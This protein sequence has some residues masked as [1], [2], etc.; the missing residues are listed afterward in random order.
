MQAPITQPM[1]GAGGDPL[2]AV[3]AAIEC[4]E[5]Y[6]EGLTKLESG[7]TA[8]AFKKEARENAAVSDEELEALA[9]KLNSPGYESA[10]QGVDTVNLRIIPRGYLRIAGDTF[11]LQDCGDLRPEA[12]DPGQIVA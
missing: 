4:D 3:R 9:D 1:D 12:L 8:A 2:D 10:K 6:R 7:L 11:S 5:H